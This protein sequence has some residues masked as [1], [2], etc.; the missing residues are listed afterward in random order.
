MLLQH[1]KPCLHYS[2]KKSKSRIERRMENMMDLKVLDIGKCL[3]AFNFR[4]LERPTSSVNISSFKNE[5]TRLWDD[6]Y[7]ILSPPI[8][9]PHLAPAPLADDKVLEALYNKDIL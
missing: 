9:L 7:A 3:D 4:V 5:L 6:L 1:V 8:D 2:I